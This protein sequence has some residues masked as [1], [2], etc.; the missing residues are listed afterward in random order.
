MPRNGS[1]HK[2]I[3][4]TYWKNNVLKIKIL[5][6]LGV[7]GR[8][9]HGPCRW[10]VAA[11]DICQLFDHALDLDRRV[12]ETSMIYVKV[13]SQLLRNSWVLVNGQYGSIPA[14]ATD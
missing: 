12:S 4:N 14:T 1:C 13:I 5:K 2:Y 10:C 6:L 9:T 3:V 11:W 7:K 8:V